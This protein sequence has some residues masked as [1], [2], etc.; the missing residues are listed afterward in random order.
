MWLIWLLNWGGFVWVLLEDVWWWKYVSF[1]IGLDIY[2]LLLLFGLLL[3]YYL[4]V[5]LFFLFLVFILFLVNIILSDLGVY[6]FI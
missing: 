5:I 4:V 3:V 1:L 6:F 2:L